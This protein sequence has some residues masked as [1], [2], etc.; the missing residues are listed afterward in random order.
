[1][2]S[3]TA[4]STSR[5]DQRLAVQAVAELVAGVAAVEIFA[6]ARVGDDL[7]RALVD[8]AAGDA[9]PDDLL[10]L[11]AA[12]GTSLDRSRAA[13]RSARRRSRCGRDRRCSL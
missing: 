4:K 5:V 8:L 11:L 13:P 7:A 2:F 6:P 10:R 9:G 3:T 1:M 12:R